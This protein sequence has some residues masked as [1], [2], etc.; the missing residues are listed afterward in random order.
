M[1]AYQVLEERSMKQL[2]DE[3]SRNHFL[4]LELDSSHISSGVALAQSVGISGATFKGNYGLLYGGTDKNLNPDG[5]VGQAVAD[6]VSA[7]TGNVDI[8]IGQTLNPAVPLM[9]TFVANSNGRFTG[10]LK[11]TIAG[12]LTEI[13]Y[14]VNSSTVLFIEVDSKGE[15]AGVLQLQQ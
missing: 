15:T 7:I 9:G 11:T 13:F 3:I 4:I 5:V 12:Q 6:G 1:F 8:N 2:S 14:V 10:T